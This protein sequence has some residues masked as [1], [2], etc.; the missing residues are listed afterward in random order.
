MKPMHDAFLLCRASKSAQPLA[1]FIRRDEVYFWLSH[2]SK[3]SKFAGVTTILLD[4][5]NLSTP[6]SAG[7]A[8]VPMAFFGGAERS[9]T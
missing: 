2:K 6:L 7:A 3:A 9:H 8:F 5:C 4:D 1:S